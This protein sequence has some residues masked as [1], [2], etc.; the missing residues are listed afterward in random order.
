[1]NR[2]STHV[3]DTSAG[4]PAQGIVVLLLRGE[5]ELSRA[6]TDAD[7]RCP[8]LVPVEMTLDATVYSLIFQV[9]EYF[10]D[11]FYPQV[12]IAFKVAAGTPHYHV[13]LLLSPFGYTTYRGS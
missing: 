11:G 3:L 1:M 4:K 10:P 8:N 6:I 9:G 5:T 12:R 13:P 2:I 7:G